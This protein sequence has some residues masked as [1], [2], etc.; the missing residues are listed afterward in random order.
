MN[1]LSDAVKIDL[2]LDINQRLFP[3]QTLLI[4]ASPS[5]EIVY[6][7]TVYINT[8]TIKEHVACYFRF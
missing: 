4:S 2:C 1:T 5:S 3:P 6:I 7:K 8:V